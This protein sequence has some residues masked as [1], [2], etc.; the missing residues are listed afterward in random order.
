M[1]EH[2]GDLELWRAWSGVLTVLPT[3]SAR[4][5]PTEMLHRFPGLSG[6]KSGAEIDPPDSRSPRA[7]VRDVKPETDFVPAASKRPASPLLM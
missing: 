6:P 2:G 4:L 5:V 3:D 7:S 1:K